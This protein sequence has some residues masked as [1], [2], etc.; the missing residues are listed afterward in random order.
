MQHVWVAPYPGRFL[1]FAWLIENVTSVMFIVLNIAFGTVSATDRWV[2][3]VDPA[4]PPEVLAEAREEFRRVGRRAR[5]RYLLDRISNGF[6]HG[7]PVVLLVVG[8][9]VS[10]ATGG[11]SGA[12]FSDAMLVTVLYAGVASIATLVTG[13][14][15]RRSVREVRDLAIEGTARSGV[16]GRNREA[17][18]IISQANQLGLVEQRRFLDHLWRVAMADQARSRYLEGSAE[19]DEGEFATLR[20]D[21]ETA[22][23]TL[24]HWTTVERVRSV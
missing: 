14:R 10:E 6:L 16:L 2:F 24:H 21:I 9:S 5:R 7:W 15:A 11:S 3:V 4:A 13:W 18:R 19:F 1:A 20:R 17:L 8:I 12:G 23:T 22:E